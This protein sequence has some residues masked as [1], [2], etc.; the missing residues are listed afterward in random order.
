MQRIAVIGLGR[1]GTVLARRL[2]ASGVQ[3]LAI[4]RQQQHV[5]EVKDEVDVAV[6]LDATDEAALKSQD[7]ERADVCVVTIGENF[8]AALLATVIAKKLGIP[9]VICRAQTAFHGEIFRQIGADEVI[10]PEVDAG[11]S[12]ARR[13]VNPHIEDLINLAEGYSLL[14]LMAPAA[15]HHQSL[16]ALHLRAKYGVNL[17]AIKR[18]VE[19]DEQQEGAEPRQ[20]ASVPKPTD[21]IQPGDVLVLVG[22]DEEL[23]KVPKE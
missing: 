3:V 12:L 18:T 21:V 15:F 8:E 2:G 19:S 6:R 9:K 13:L 20:M 4:D 14:E 23:A 10:Q 7:V 1:F 17:V 5:N 22:S 16:K 11:E